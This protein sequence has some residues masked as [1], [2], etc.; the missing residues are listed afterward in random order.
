M[1]D[2]KVLLYLSSLE[3]KQDQTAILEMEKFAKQTGVPIMEKMGFDFVRQILKLKEPKL[4]LEIGSAIGY[5]AIRMALEAPNSLIYTIEKDIERYN[6]AVNNIKN[7]KLENQIT[8]INADALKINK[9]IEDV[10]Q[11]DLI[12]IDAAKGKN[13]EFFELYEKKLAPNGIIITDNVLFKGIVASPENATKRI[14]PMINK[15]REFNEWLKN[16][17]NYDT[18]IY[19]I[20]DGVAISIRKG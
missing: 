13:K 20:G 9:V 7:F 6:I 3:Y 10:N 4:I 8:I 2:E 15:I 16:N 12:F 19:P 5:S 11:F 1:L 14:K 18:A 17:P